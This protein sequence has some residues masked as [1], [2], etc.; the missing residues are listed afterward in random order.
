V[1]KTRRW[2]QQAFVRLI[3]K[4]GY[5]AISIQDIATEAETA[6]VT[7]YR[8]YRNKEELLTDCLN[9]LY[10]ELAQKTERLSAEGLA[11][12]YSPISTLYAHMQEQEALY[13]ILFSSRGT[14][15][16]IERMR[17]HM[18]MRAEEAIRGMVGP[19]RADIPLAII[20]QHAASAQLGLAM[21]WL[22]QNKPY[23]AT[24]MAQ[25]SLWLTLSGLL[26]TLGVNT[27]T[28]PLPTLSA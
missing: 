12:G 13:R 27:F 28:P 9:T 6:R 19:V 3:L 23:P 24:Y 17:H 7:F 14:Q 22:E 5:D 18:A 21:W 25:I 16:V 20:A 4:H 8:H 1:R 15:T 10:E 26:T 11:R 2:L